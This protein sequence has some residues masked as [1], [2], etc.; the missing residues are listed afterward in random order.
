[1]QSELIQ[2]AV[3]SHVLCHPFQQHAAAVHKPN[4]VSRKWDRSSL[5]LLLFIHDKMSE[6]QV[7]NANAMDFPQRRYKKATFDLKLHDAE[8]KKKGINS[9]IKHET[10]RLTIPLHTFVDDKLSS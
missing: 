3:P 10:Y 2:H 7:Y 1:M 5:P 4:G 9:A 8:M 6:E